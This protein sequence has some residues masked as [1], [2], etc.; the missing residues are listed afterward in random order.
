MDSYL[1]WV[2]DKVEC[3]IQMHALGIDPRQ[4]PDFPRA[5]TLSIAFS[6]KAGQIVGAD[7]FLRTTQL[8]IDG[9]EGYR[10]G[11]TSKGA[12]LFKKK[13]SQYIFPLTLQHPEMALPQGF[14]ET[15]GPFT[16]IAGSVLVCEEL[17]AKIANAG[18]T[19]FKVAAEYEVSGA[20]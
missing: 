9:A 13:G 19:G 6:Q 16:G 5:S 15:G 2:G 18:L 14:I 3:S 7:A 11:F 20:G 10:I 17:W 12:Q 8:D 4:L 1:D